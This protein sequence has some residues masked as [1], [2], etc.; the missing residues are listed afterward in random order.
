M[1]I[2]AKDVSPFLT[3]VKYSEKNQEREKQA[4]VFV[5]V[6]V[7]FG[8]LNNL[9]YLQINLPLVKYV[10]NPPEIKQTNDPIQQSAEA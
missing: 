1:G 7:Y 2:P 8:A 9:A 10:T 5:P 6:I 3:Y 4:F